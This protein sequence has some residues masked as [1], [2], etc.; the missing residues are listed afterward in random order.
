MN[1]KVKF[2]GDPDGNLVLVV[3]LMIETLDYF[4]FHVGF[5]E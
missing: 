3:K 4:D 1:C 2:K 5:D